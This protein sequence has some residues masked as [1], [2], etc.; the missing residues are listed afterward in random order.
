MLTLKIKIHDIRAKDS[1]ESGMKNAIRDIY[2]YPF[3]LFSTRMIYLYMYKL[4]TNRSTHMSAV[5]YHD[6]L[7][8]KKKK[9]EFEINCI[10]LIYNKVS[11]CNNII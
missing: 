3:I 7:I 8:T 9:K 10:I 11:N 1:T 5:D 4:H 6:N 2:R